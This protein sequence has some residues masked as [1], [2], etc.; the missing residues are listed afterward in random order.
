MASTWSTLLSSWASRST[1]LVW[2]GREVLGTVAEDLGIAHEGA[3]DAGGQ[4]GEP[5]APRGADG[6]A[7]AGEKSREARR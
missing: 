2:V 3:E 1:R 7:H 4:V 6:D 5:A